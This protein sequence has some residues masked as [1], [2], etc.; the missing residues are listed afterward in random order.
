MGAWIED[1]LMAR[2]HVFA[3]MAFFVFAGHA[4]AQAIRE[5]P[6]VPAD[7]PAADE[8]FMQLNSTLDEP[9]RFCLDVPG[10]RRPGEQG[11]VGWRTDWPL[12]AHT[13]KTEIANAH[14]FFVD[15]LLSRAALTR[16]HQIRF[17][18]LPVCMEIQSPGPAPGPVREDS[19]VLLAAC[20]DTPWQRFTLSPEGQIR[21]ELDATKCLTIG[22]ESFEAGN[23]APGEPWRRR[24]LSVST[25][26]ALEAERQ[27]WR[28]Q[29]PPA[30]SQ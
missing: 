8:V 18:R 23:R 9:R 13:C 1:T 3:L 10:F 19:V 22:V 25:C 27:T 21:P 30:D 16:D 7:P 29:T 6:L 26:S 5:A 11:L 17:T 2:T 4:S 24:D 20:S 12:G 28:T 15:Q 14:A